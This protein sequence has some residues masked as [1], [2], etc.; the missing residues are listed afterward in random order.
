[1]L[2]ILEAAKTKL[3]YYYSKTDK[4]YCDIFAI[5]TIIAPSNKLQFFSTQE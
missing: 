3:L 4:I 1:M 5:G 2:Y